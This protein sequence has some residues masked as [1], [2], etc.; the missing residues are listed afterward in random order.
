MIC[1]A[2]RHDEMSRLRFENKT[3]ERE[4]QRLVSFLKKTQ[5][6]IRFYVTVTW[7]ALAVV[8]VIDVYKIVSVSQAVQQEVSP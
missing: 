7:I 5:S 3:L 6:D 2:Y 4:N 8:A 1:E